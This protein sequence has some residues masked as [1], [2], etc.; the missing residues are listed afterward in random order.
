MDGDRQMTTTRQSGTPAAPAAP[1]SQARPATPS[2]APAAMAL[3]LLAA[4][5]PADTGFTLPEGDAGAG[6]QAFVELGCTSCHEVAGAEG[7]RD[8]EVPAER[9]IRLG[10]RTDAPIGYGDLVTSI[11]NPS[12]RVSAENLPDGIDAQG[13]SVMPSLNEFMTVEELVDIVTFLEGQYALEP[14]DRTDFPAY[15]P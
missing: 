1:A 13:N 2:R 4:C 6:R 10:G 8:P 7:L 15:G 12:H 14:Y 9:T 5:A 3:A 11:I